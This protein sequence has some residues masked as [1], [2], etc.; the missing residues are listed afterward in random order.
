MIQLFVA[1]AVILG[2]SYIIYHYGPKGWRT[3]LAKVGSA[4][5]A[6]VG[7]LVSA[8]EMVPWH[9]FLDEKAAYGAVIGVVIAG[10]ALR[11]VTDTKV[12][13]PD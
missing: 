5:V 2:A 6:T 3:V 8:F 10:I 11:F 7:A 1:L 9:A 4:F 13:E 12:G